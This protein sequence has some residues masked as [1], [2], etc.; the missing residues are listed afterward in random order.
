MCC[1]PSMESRLKTK[2]MGYIPDKWVSH[3]VRL[4]LLH[5]V[6]RIKNKWEKGLNLINICR[7][8]TSDLKVNAR[9]TST[10]RIVWT[11]TPHCSRETVS[12]STIIIQ[13]RR[14]RG[15]ERGQMNPTGGQA[16]ERLWEVVL[17]ETL[18]TLTDCGVWRTS[19]LFD[20]RLSI[21]PTSVLSDALRATDAETSV[22][23]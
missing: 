17:S 12:W 15:W 7:F 11:L 14:S 23:F 3:R 4:T 8:V 1:R 9:Q 6:N 16:V 20:L 18:R 19:L 13:L 21:A 10:P 2:D 22:Y 5:G